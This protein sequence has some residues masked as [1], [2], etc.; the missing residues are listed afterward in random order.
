MTKNFQSRLI[1]ASRRELVLLGF[2]VLCRY[3]WTLAIRLLGA[4]FHLH[5]QER[6]AQSSAERRE[7]GRARN[8]RSVG[9]E[10][11]WA[12]VQ[13]RGQ[14]GVSQGL[15]PCSTQVELATPT[16]PVPPKKQTMRD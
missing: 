11:E 6:T 9:R 12:E 5:G 14:A 8:S 2:P 16:R 15:S 1:S 13:C 3:G 7:P 10:A 4:A